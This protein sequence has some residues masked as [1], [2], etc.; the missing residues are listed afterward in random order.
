MQAIFKVAL[1]CLEILSG[2][3]VKK[4][5]VRTADRQVRWKA[6]WIS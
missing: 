3:A 1:R 5:E 2:A 4:F 6:L